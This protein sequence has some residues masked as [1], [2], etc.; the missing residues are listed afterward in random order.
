MAWPNGDI[1]FGPAK[2]CLAGEGMVV[3]CS[4]A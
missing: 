2:V 1:I 3:A 4:V